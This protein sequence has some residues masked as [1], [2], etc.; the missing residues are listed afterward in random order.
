MPAPSAQHSNDSSSLESS[1]TSLE[2]LANI[3]SILSTAGAQRNTTG[4]NQVNQSQ[5]PHPSVPQTDSVPAAS[6]SFRPESPTTMLSNSSAA[7]LMNAAS[8][9]VS[10]PLESNSQPSHGLYN[11]Y[12]SNNSV[13]MNIITQTMPEV[14]AIIRKMKDEL[15]GKD[16][17]ERPNYSYSTLIALAIRKS[18]TGRLTLTDIYNWISENFPYYQTDL[19]PSWKNSVRHNLS[20]NKLFM[21]IPREHGD[22]GKGAYWGINPNAS[23]AN[24]IKARRSS[25]IKRKSVSS[26]DERPPKTQSVTGNTTTDQVPGQQYLQS[27]P[28]SNNSSLFM[29]QDSVHAPYFAS[30]QF[31]QPPHHYLPGINE[32]NSMSGSL[33]NYANLQQQIPGVD[34]NYKISSSNNLFNA[35]LTQNMIAFQ[36]VPPQQMQMHQQVNG[37]F[38]NFNNL[39][40]S[41][42][43]TASITALLQQQPRMH[44]SQSQQHLHP[45]IPAQSIIPSSSVPVKAAAVVS[46]DEETFDYEKII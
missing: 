6:N 21:R 2:W 45:L 31:Q 18:T 28:V 8:Q 11:N 24:K 22:P 13:E 7:A 14:D 9:I 32:L 3:S 46:D 36:S 25:G 38:S 4:E 17:N 42:N 35:P 15:M 12:V 34:S 37:L 26:G 23:N 33:Y 43:G 27:Q 5:D 39:M 40:H 44:P 20:F 41:S 1:L 16:P 19:N 10:A 29:F 30:Q